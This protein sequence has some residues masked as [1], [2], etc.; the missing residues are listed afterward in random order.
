MQIITDAYPVPIANSEPI[1]CICS[2]PIY[3][4]VADRYIK[5]LTIDSIEKIYARFSARNQANPGTVD[6][7]IELPVQQFL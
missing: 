3:A 5:R 4:I 7:A 6:S 2:K 1:I